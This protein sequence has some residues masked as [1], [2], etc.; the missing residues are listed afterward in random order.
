M[1]YYRSWNNFLPSDDLPLADHHPSFSIPSD[2]F[3]QGFAIHQYDTSDSK[4][5]RNDFL[6]FPFR[7][8]RA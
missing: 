5:R 1:K 2:E 8:L 4:R 3:D 7:N 6:T